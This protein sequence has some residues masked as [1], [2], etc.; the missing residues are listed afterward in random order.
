MGDQDSEVLKVEQELRQLEREEL[1]RQRENILFQE[2]RAKARLQNNRHSSEN[3]FDDMYSSSYQDGINYR[4]SM[5]ELQHIP[6]D[7]RKSMPDVPNAYYRPVPE[8]DLQY[9]KSM[10]NIQHAYHK[11]VP[12]YHKPVD[13]DHRKSMPDIQRSAFKS[14]PPLK[15][16]P[17]MPGK[18]IRPMTKEQRDRYLMMNP[19][20]DSVPVANGKPRQL[21]RH[22]LQAL[23]AVPK[24]RHLPVDNWIQPRHNVEKNTKQHWLVQV[25]HK[26]CII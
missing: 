1:K 21:S 9:R 23:S 16:Q 3:I 13:M 25:M 11:S 15:K 5:P 18:P 22:S 17:I 19:I 26:L 8:L 12:E 7:Y 24:N 20:P 2:S 4:K 14:P 6:L 10:P